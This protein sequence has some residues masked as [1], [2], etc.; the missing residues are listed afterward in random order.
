[1]TCDLISGALENQRLWRRLAESEAYTR[2]ILEALPDSLLVISADGELEDMIISREEPNLWLAEELRHTSLREFL[3]PKLVPLM[4]DLMARVNA[5]ETPA[6]QLFT[7]VRQGREIHYE[8]RATRYREDGFLG[9]VRD[10]TQRVEDEKA[11]RSLALELSEVEET[12]RREL[13][14]LLHDGIGQDLSAVHYQ[15]QACLQGEVPDRDRIA[16]MSS[17][18]QDAMR[19]TQDLTFDLSPPLLHEL[20]LTAALQA[21]ARRVE[22]EFG[23]VCAVTADGDDLPPGAERSVFLYRIARELVLNAV[24]HSG[25]DRIEIALG[26]DEDR[27]TLTVGDNGEGMET[28]RIAAAGDGKAGG[29]GLFSIR[30]RLEPLGGVLNVESLGGAKVTVTLPRETAAEN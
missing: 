21:L 18:L 14:L 15:I 6:V 17:I 3:G 7:I 27:V 12:Q 1:M 4:E 10:V 25:G 8:V 11:L 29:F 20:G 26:V 13:A 24:K 16:M 19:K 28:A 22:R 30:Q 2:A 23:L 5:G 9:L